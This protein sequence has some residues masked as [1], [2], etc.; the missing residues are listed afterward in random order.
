M[1]EKFYFETWKSVLGSSILHYY[2]GS[3]VD[4]VI[5]QSS[6]KIGFYCDH[7]DTDLKMVA[8]IKF[9]C[10]NIHLN[11]VIIVSPDSGVVVIRFYQSVTNLTFLDAS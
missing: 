7:E 8:C 4:R 5:S 9:L 11:R 10:D 3:A 1:I 6:E 2:L